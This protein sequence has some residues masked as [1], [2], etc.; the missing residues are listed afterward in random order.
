MT[1]QTQPLDLQPMQLPAAPSWLPLA[2]GW[3]ALFAGAAVILVIAAIVFLYSRKKRLRAKKAALKLLQ[4]PVQPHTASSAFE[5]L[6]Q[7]AL[8][9]FP[10]PVVASLSGLSWYEF[11]DSQ[12]KTPRFVANYEHWQKVLYKNATDDNETQLIHDC[13]TWVEQA[14]PPK[15]GKRRA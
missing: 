15:R 5:I 10:R 3:W 4:H 2:W 8:S 7:A 11:L 12:M 1:T 13:Q 6:R 9:Y 14:L